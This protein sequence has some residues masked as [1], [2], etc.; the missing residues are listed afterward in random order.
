V[1]QTAVPGL[2]VEAARAAALAE[3]QRRIRAMGWWILAGFVT[4]G[5]GL[6]LGPVLFAVGF[7]AV[8]LVLYLH[9]PFAFGARGAVLTDLGRGEVHVL[10]GSNT[11]R[12]EVRP[13]GGEPFR[14]VVSGARLEGWTPSEAHDPAVLFGNPDKGGFVVAVVGLSDGSTR[15]L[16]IRGIRP[17]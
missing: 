14:G 5:V 12:V 15:V 8:A 13:D 7:G 2:D 10:H 6:V 11:T 1:G 17:A 9:G 16:G 4:A 3:Q